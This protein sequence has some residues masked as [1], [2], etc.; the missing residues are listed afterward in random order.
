MTEF[1]RD[2]EGLYARRGAFP[3][4]EEQ[5]RLLVDNLQDYAIFSLDTQE[6]RAI[7]AHAPAF[8][9]GGLLLQPSPAAPRTQLFLR[10]EDGEMLADHF[11]SRIAMDA[12]CSCVP[13]GDA[14]L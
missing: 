3:E 2:N 13:S 14:P 7:L 9:P 12:F 1:S 8:L 10:K 6:A 11:V 5:L 4:A